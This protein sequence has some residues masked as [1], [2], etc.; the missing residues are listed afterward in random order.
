MTSEQA[1]LDAR[2]LSGAAL[3]S[4]L[5]NSRAN[6]WACVQ[7]LTDAQWMPPRHVGVNPIA[8]ELGHMAWFA[9]YWVLRG[10]HG[11]DDQGFAASPIAPRFTSPDA[12]FDSARLAHAK[13]WEIALPSRG[14]LKDLMQAQLEACLAALPKGA[15]RAETARTNPAS[16]AALYHHRLALFHEDMHAE[17][18]RWLRATLGYGAPADLLQPQIHPPGQLDVQ[19]GTWILG[20][21]VLPDIIRTSVNPTVADQSNQTDPVGK[22]SKFDQTG[23]PGFAF[24][25]EIGV[26]TVSLPSFTID[27]APVCAGDFAEFVDAGGY[28]TPRFWPGDAGVWRAQSPINHPSTWRKTS[29]GG[30][31]HRWFD[32][33]LPLEPQRP[34]IHVNAFEAQAYCLWAKRRLP[35][36][37]EWEFAALAAATASRFHWG[38]A[39]WEWTSDAFEPYKGFLPGPYRE[40]SALWFGNHREL[41]GGAFA[42]HTRMQNARYRNFFLPQRS[43]IFAGF[44]TVAL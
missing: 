7:D 24:D 13:R 1:S 6:T 30:W 33:F 25:N 8:W 41:R 14:A 36:A 12:N 18:L 42:T 11:R 19:G 38:N 37:A 9:E 17:A 10:P 44:R 2:Q 31:Q 5:Q 21:P 22:F 29:A 4:A 28:D 27:C 39:V 20:K 15:A 16:Q 23:Q 3:A 40:Y 26:Q 34:V 35:R 32:H 43:D